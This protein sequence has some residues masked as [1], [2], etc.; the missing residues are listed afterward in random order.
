M[1]K[2]K[3]YRQNP[4]KGSPK[5]VVAMFHGLHSHVNRG[6]HIAHYFAERGIATVGLDSRGFGASEGHRGYI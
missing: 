2:L 6:A 1:Y 3:T 4:K 5:A